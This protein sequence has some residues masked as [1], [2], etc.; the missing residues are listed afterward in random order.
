MQHLFNCI[1]PDVFE[2]I[3]RK[4]RFQ[5]Q[6][7]LSLT[8]KYVYRY[9]RI[10]YF[11]EDDAWYGR[12]LTPGA[13]RQPRFS[14]L[15][16]VPF[17]AI[18][19]IH[20][21]A[22]KKVLT[23]FNGR[24]LVTVTLPN[25]SCT[26]MEFNGLQKL[27]NLFV[28]GPTHISIAQ[29]PGISYLSTCLNFTSIDEL[30][31]F[32]KLRSLCLRNC[33]GDLSFLQKLVNMDTLWI[34]SIDVAEA[35]QMILPD[36]PNLIDL[37]TNIMKFG[38]YYQLET[39]HLRCESGIDTDSVNRMIRIQPRCRISVTVVAD[40]KLDYQFI[41]NIP[42]LHSFDYQ[43]STEYSPQL[44]PFSLRSLK[45][46]SLTTQESIYQ[47]INL[48]SL[49]NLSPYIKSI[50]H[51]EN[52]THLDAGSSVT[53]LDQLPST[54]KFLDMGSLNPYTEL[55]NLTN[56]VELKLAPSASYN[57]HPISRLRIEI[58]D[59]TRC[60]YLRNLESMRHLRRLVCDRDSMRSNQEIL[61]RTTILD[62]NGTVQRRKFRIG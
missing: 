24:H 16:E 53:V 39:L 17:V 19:R 23:H 30:C 29:L 43:I 32:T 48:E 50:S 34:A 6:I 47:L 9:L 7:R 61:P 28:M 42:N 45:M 41:E 38:E 27:K 25:V 11:C 8:C 44:L 5:E 15:E 20:Y 13:L 12:N 60:R 31:S 59:T 55:R 1:P 14:Q 2:I 26:Q 52:L 56:L 35:D 36:L 33:W 21:G 57:L 58:L 22:G 46:N 51:M 54:L 18:N 62:S 37:T 3:T 49:F 4:L 40:V 10:T